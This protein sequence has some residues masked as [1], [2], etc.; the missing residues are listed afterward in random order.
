MI[1][2]DPEIKKLISDKIKK[3]EAKPEIVTEVVD[4]PVIETVDDIKEDIYKKQ[5]S[6]ISTVNTE[7]RKFGGL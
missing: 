7:T 1:A 3:T 5:D 6:S 4:L 2:D